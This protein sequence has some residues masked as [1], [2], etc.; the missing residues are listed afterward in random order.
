MEFIHLQRVHWHPSLALMNLHLWQRGATREARSIVLSIIKAQDPAPTLQQIFRL[1]VQQESSK[2]K[3]TPTP[4]QRVANDGERTPQPQYPNHSI[5]SMR[6]LKSVVIPSLLRTKD[7]E[8]VH[9]THNL[10]AEEMEHRLQSMTRSSRKDVASLSS[11]M[12]V[13][14]FRIRT[15]KP[16]GTKPQPPENTFGKDVGVGA[17]WSHLNKRRQRS[18]VLSVTR[19]VRWLKQLEKVRSEG[20]AAG[21]EAEDATVV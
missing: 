12:D 5:R 20:L 13:W 18:R 15:H 14:R 8:R 10:T 19:D 16:T 17:D 3:T 9:E 2:G 21:K 1:A 4:E 11:T 7:V 6:Y